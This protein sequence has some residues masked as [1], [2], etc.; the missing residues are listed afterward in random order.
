[1]DENHSEGD[2]HIT[3]VTGGI[4]SAAERVGTIIVDTAR[5]IAETSEMGERVYEQGARGA[6]YGEPPAPSRTRNDEG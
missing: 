4:R 3:G 5:K 2:V 1:M 6:R